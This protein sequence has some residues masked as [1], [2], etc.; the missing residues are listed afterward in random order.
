MGKPID[1]L[2]TQKSFYQSD[3]Y[4]DQNV[5]I[6]R[7]ETEILIEKA[8][9]LIKSNK[10]KKI[11]EIGSGS[12]ALGL[13][14]ILE[15]QDSLDFVFTDIDSKALAVTKYNCFLKKNSIKQHRVEFKLMDRLKGISVKYD[16]IVSNP[17]YIKEDRDRRGVH[18]SVH[19]YEPHI[20]LYLKDDE[21]NQWFT[22]FFQQVYQCLNNGGSFLM[23]GHED[24][25]SQ[26]LE[27]A[28]S[29]GFSGYIQDDYTNRNRFLY[30]VKE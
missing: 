30:L 14:I 18:S 13:S 27:V 4:V 23:E 19:Q 25:L 26:Q 5:L 3:F 6:P 24:H 7:N 8:I 9:E 15:I 2:N 20:A 10:Y 21:Y 29:I 12:G 28:K 22:D 16:L 17:P 11:I 1:Y